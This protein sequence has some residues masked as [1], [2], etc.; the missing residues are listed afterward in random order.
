MLCCYVGEPEFKTSVTLSKGKKYIKKHTALISVGH[1]TRCYQ[2]DPHCPQQETE[3]IRQ[4][5][6]VRGQ[7]GRFIASTAISIYPH[8]AGWAL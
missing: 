2:S 3:A 5:H 8:R 4:T 1:L 7:W 6:S